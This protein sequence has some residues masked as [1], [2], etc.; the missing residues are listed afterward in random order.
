MKKIAIFGSVILLHLSGCAFKT[1]EENTVQGNVGNPKEIKP[2]ASHAT[3]L[4]TLVFG[5]WQG[6]IPCADCPG[7]NYQLTL[8]KDRTYE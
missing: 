3:A 4:E 1:P 7:I 6:T 2:F 5:P 8:Q